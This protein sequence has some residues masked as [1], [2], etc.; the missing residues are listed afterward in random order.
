MA[1][2]KE[3]TEGEASLPRG[4]GSTADEAA[5]WRY[6]V[7]GQATAEKL[8]EAE[9]RVLEAERGNDRRGLFRALFYVCNN[10][11]YVGRPD[12][13]VVAFSR[14]LTMCERYP[15]LFQDRDVQWEHKWIVPS[16][17]GFP[18]VSRSAIEEACDRLAAAYSRNAFSQR[19]VSGVRAKVSQLLGEP[20]RAREWL[21][22]RDELPRDEKADCAA[23]DLSNTMDMLNCEDRDAEAFEAAQPVLEGKV[24]DCQPNGPY[25]FLS[26]LLVPCLRLGRPGVALRYHRWG[27]PAT[28]GKARRLE[29][30]PGHVAF[31]ALAGE[32]P[33]ALRALEVN[34]PVVLGSADWHSRR[35][36]FWSAAILARRLRAWG[37]SRV[38][39][40]LPDAAGVRA[41]DGE[42]SA[43]ELADWIDGQALE[44]ASAFDRRN[45]NRYFQ[46]RLDGVAALDRLRGNLPAE[47]PP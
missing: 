18:T 40:L 27:Y 8:R 7:D 21:N 6:F 19:S 36:F 41:T 26:E 16:L 30:I 32:L 25:H 10:A 42:V 13:A 2:G 43:S 20:E 24:N 12:K 39:L 35:A 45:G 14:R 46:D 37:P 15:E 22:R 5:A 38:R 1:A 31:L 11:V 47:P 33:L 4:M 29:D 9:Q 3:D 34:L 17:A 28:E 44:L 23:C